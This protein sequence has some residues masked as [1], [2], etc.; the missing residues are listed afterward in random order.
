MY[1]FIILFDMFR[2][3]F[4]HSYA[5][6]TKRAFFRFVCRNFEVKQSLYFF[7]RY[8]EFCFTTRAVNEQTYTYDLTTGLVYNIYYFL[9]RTTSCYDVF[10]DKYA[11]AWLNFKATAQCHN[12]FFAFCENRTCAKCF[13]HFVS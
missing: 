3:T 11:C 12:T 8:A 1:L 2:T 10:N 9:Y 7:M 5:I 6:F 4:C 13:T